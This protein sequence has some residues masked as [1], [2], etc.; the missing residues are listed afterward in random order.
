MPQKIATRRKRQIVIVFDEFQEITTLKLPIERS[1]RAK[2]QHHDKV[3]YCFMGSKRHLLDELFL[4]KNKPLYRIAKSMPLEKIPA[5]KFNLF[6]HSRFKSVDMVI[7]GDV[8]EQILKITACHPYYTQQLCHEIFN[9]SFSETL[10]T[11]GISPPF[12]YMTYS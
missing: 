6:I 1:L 7:E 3:A 11:L 9:I 4:D 2:I 5:E 10:F 8:I 12:R